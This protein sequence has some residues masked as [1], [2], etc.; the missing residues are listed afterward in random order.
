MVETRPDPDRAVDRE[1]IDAHA[2]KLVAEKARRDAE[3]FAM[4]QDQPLSLKETLGV[5]LAVL[6]VVFVVGLVMMT[7][8]T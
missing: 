8:R 7:K 2:R 3:K 6:A 1:A 5:V 4:L